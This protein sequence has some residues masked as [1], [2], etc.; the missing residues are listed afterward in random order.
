MGSCTWKSGGMCQ[1]SVPRQDLAHLEVCDDEA[2]KSLGR[3]ILQ[4]RQS[5]DC[6]MAFCAQVARPSLPFISAQLRTTG[7]AA[8][9]AIYG[10]PPSPPFGVV[11]LFALLEQ[12]PQIPGLL[13][14]STRGP[15]RPEL[16]VQELQLAKGAFAMLQLSLQAVSGPRAPV[17]APPMQILFHAGGEGRRRDGDRPN[18]QCSRVLYVGYVALGSCLWK[19]DKGTRGQWGESS[20][21]AACVRLGLLISYCTSSTS[22][23]CVCDRVCRLSIYIAFPYTI[24][25]AYFY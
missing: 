9:S 14:W 24:N 2:L 21:F 7:E 12:I 3:E 13:S 15:V 23:L 22:F 16:E 10:L 6:S 5:G 20:L 1:G 17:A 25:R 18:L 11:A 4:R 19:G 8:Y